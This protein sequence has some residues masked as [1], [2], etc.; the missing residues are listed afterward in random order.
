MYWGRARTP[1]LKDQCH[2][3]VS[4]TEFWLNVSNLKEIILCW[5]CACTNDCG[6]A[7]R[8]CHFAPPMLE[9]NHYSRCNAAGGLALPAL[10]PKATLPVTGSDSLHKRPIA[11]SC[12]HC[13]RVLGRRFQL[14]SPTSGN[15]K[16]AS[17]HRRRESS[18]PAMP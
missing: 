5:D 2:V 18:C 11:T 6:S 10:Q 3:G 1:C 9:V 7:G 4:N 12:D 17:N 8:I 14:F 13:P 16:D 15:S